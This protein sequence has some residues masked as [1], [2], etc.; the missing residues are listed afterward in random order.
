VTGSSASATSLVSFEQIELFHSPTHHSPNAIEVALEPEDDSHMDQ[1]YRI[2]HDQ[3]DSEESD[4]EDSKN[5]Q[6]DSDD[7]KVITNPTSIIQ[8]HK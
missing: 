8:V 5:E 1:F 6:K 2:D 4:D 3:P 7:E